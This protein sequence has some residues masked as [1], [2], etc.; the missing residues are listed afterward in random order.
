MKMI[1][2]ADDVGYTDVCNIGSFETIYNGVVTSADTMLD[3]PGTVDALKRLRELPWITVGWH[4]HM[5]GSPILDPSKVPTIYNPKN[6]H[7]R[8]DLKTA[9]DVDYNEIL[10]ELRAEIER[11]IQYLGRTPDTA[12][13]TGFGPN[14]SVF[15]AAQKQVVEEYE[16]P[17]S[18]ARRMHSLENGELEFGMVDPQWADC[19]IYKAELGGS[20]GKPRDNTVMTDSIQAQFLYDPLPYFYEDRGR[21]FELPKDS[22]FEHSWHPGYVDYYVYRLGDQGPRARNVITSRTVDV[23]ALC[24]E[25]LKNWIR[26]KKVELVNWKD[27]LYGTH[28]YQNNLRDTGSNLFML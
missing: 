5:W 13:V 15:A 9:E 2:Q 12:A 27:A 14:P 4:C 25:D 7:F 16:I 3:T 18:C 1:I 8:Q 21:M 24:S 28:E 11:C 20:K 10:T 19:K 22:V 6:G 23:F 17:H 26:E